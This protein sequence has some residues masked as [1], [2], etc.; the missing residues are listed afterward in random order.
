MS[1]QVGRRPG[2]IDT[3]ADILE[4]AKACFAEE[5]YEK[6]SLRGIARRAGVDPALVHHYFD[7]KP[8]LF[9]ATVNIGRDPSE[10]FDEVQASSRKGETLVRAFLEEWE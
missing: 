4:A 10:I 9:M 6:A 7:G 5:G 3:R 1:G 8:E 2:G